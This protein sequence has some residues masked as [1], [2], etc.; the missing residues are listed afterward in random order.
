MTSPLADQTLG[1]KKR[2]QDDLHRWDELYRVGV[3]IEICLLDDKAKPVNAHPLINELS[4]RFDMDPE[5]GKCQFEVKTEPIS[6]HDLSSLNTFFV[7]F[8]DFLEKSI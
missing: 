3:E 4:T 2:V 5:Y 1:L 6:M 7:D 8:I